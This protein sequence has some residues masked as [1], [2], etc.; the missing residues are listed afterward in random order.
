MPEQPDD[1]MQKLTDELME[2]LEIC[3]ACTNVL[4]KDEKIINARFIQSA[5]L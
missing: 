2:T 1:Q 3:N 5:A 4:N